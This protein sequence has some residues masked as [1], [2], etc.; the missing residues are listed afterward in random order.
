[1]KRPISRQVRKVQKWLFDYL[2]LEVDPYDFSHAI[3]DWMEEEGIAWE[4]PDQPMAADLTAAQ[5]KKFEAWVV[6]REKDIEWVATGDVYAPA[7]LYFNEVS[8]LPAGTW[9][10]HFT[11]ETPFEAFDRGTT[12]EG[13]ALSTHKREKDTPDCAKNLGDEIGSAEVVFGFAFEARARSPSYGRMDVMSHG[14]SKY[15]HNAVLF[16]TDGGVRAWH[17]GDEEYQ[18][19]F[20]LCSE[21]NV[22][23]LYHPDPG[24][25]KIETED[26]GEMTFGSI[27]HVIAYAEKTE[28]LELRGAPGRRLVRLERS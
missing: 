20:P 1:M 13:L 5:L 8:K 4:S 11:S 15:G 6:D 19:I 28:L 17:V 3:P 14:L 21:Y 7:Y 2:D 18:V 23:P 16:Q 10:V 22:I 25:V 12:L 27:E 26:G 9:C 24:E